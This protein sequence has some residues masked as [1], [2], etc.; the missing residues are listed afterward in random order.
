VICQLDG[1]LVLLLSHHVPLKTIVRL[2]LLQPEWHAMK[3]TSAQKEQFQWFL[4]LPDIYV[5]A[6]VTPSQAKLIAQLVIIAQVAPTQR[7]N[8]VALL[9]TIA[10]LTRKHRSLASLVL[11]M[12]RLSQNQVLYA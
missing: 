4:A 11:T 7:L 1:A 12:L 8:K 9:V 3:D 2:A 6:L 5:M 10:L